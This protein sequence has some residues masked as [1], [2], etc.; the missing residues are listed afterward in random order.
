MKHAITHPTSAEFQTLAQQSRFVPVYRQLTADTLTPVTA[1]QR[2][3]SGYWAFLF[4]SVIG[5]E[6][7]GRFSFVGSNPF[8]TITATGS[9]VVIDHISNERRELE[10]ADPL[11][12]LDSLVSQYQ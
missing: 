6:K 12:E 4:E 11:K 8:L 2:I 9:R 3:A 10:S 7:V 5:G 1:Y